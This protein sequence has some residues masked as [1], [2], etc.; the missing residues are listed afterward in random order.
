MAKVKVNVHATN[1][2]CDAEA[3]TKAMTLAPQTY[4]PAKKN[5]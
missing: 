3:N 1:K 5:N 4:V 2:Q